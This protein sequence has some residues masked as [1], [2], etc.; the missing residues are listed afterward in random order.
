MLNFSSLLRKFIYFNLSLPNNDSWLKHTIG[1]WLT[2]TKSTRCIGIWK[3]YQLV[4]KIFSLFPIVYTHLQLR[5]LNSEHWFDIILILIGTNDANIADTNKISIFPL[6]Y[7]LRCWKATYG[8]GSSELKNFAR[9]KVHLANFSRLVNVY[10][11]H[12]KVK[13]NFF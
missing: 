9:S 8:S 12:S 6:F 1:K 5:K 4:S 7:M 11:F 10:Q 3:L 13:K 2:S